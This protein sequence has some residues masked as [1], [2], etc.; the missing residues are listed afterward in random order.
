M[1]GSTRAAAAFLGILVLSTAGGRAAA[2]GGPAAPPPNGRTEAAEPNGASD[3]DRAK[4]AMGEIRSLATAVEA[5]A[6]DYN[7]YPKAGSL[8][9]LAPLV[10]PTYIRTMPRLD[11]WG[12]SYVYAPWNKEMSYR[13][14]S[15]GAD[16]TIAPPSL[17][18]TDTESPRANPTY[19]DDLVFV[20]GRF[21]RYADE[22][23]RP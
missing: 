9:D 21:V 23:T 5:Y 14:V 13:I 20:N 10:E 3:A 15:G 17:A 12:K 18:M 11:P 2:Q 4:V 8:D 6:V 1:N 19:K 22:T 7:Q 16:G